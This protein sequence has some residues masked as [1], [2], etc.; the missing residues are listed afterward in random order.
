MT[1]FL[2]CRGNFLSG[3]A[4]VLDRSLCHVGHN[5]CPGQ[6]RSCQ[7]PYI[8]QCWTIIVQCYMTPVC[9]HNFNRKLQGVK[10]TVKPQAAA[11]SS[12]YNYAAFSVQIFLGSKVKIKL[13]DPWFSFQQT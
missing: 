3:V 13:P 12:Q 8:V 9:I 4:E 10:S 5:H 2:N 11:L 6:H 7:G 1:P